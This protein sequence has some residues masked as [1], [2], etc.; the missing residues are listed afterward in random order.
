[1]PDAPFEK[2]FTKVRLLSNLEAFATRPDEWNTAIDR[3]RDNLSTFASLRGGRLRRSS[4]VGK[5]RKAKPAAANR[6]APSYVPRAYSF[7]ILTNDFA[8]RR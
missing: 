1:M 4:F 2:L 7:V 5:S 8:A 6:T 3:V